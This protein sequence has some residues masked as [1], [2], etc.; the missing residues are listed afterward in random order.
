[1]TVIEYE[2]KYDNLA[3]TCKLAALGTAIEF[4]VY[5]G[6][7]LAMIVENFNGFIYGLDSFEGLP[8]TWRDGYPQGHFA[9]DTIPTVPGA[10][11]IVGRF[12]QTL[13][14][15]LRQIPD[16]ITLVHFDADIYSSTIY[17]LNT[18]TNCLAKTCFFVFD[19]YDNYPGWEQHEHRAFTEWLAN[20]PNKKATL[21]S[22]VTNNQPKTF[23]IEEVTLENHRNPRPTHHAVSAF[24]SKSGRSELLPKT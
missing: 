22:A 21:I 7:S 17:A 20:H 14:H 16:A 12:E 1:M 6:N 11:I 9:T 3:A 18:I 2:S 8:E 19:E 10:V 23:L 15:L 4:G 5:S 24:Y 13:E